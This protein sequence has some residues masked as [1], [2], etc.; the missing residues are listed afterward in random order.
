MLSSAF[1]VGLWTILFWI[2]I[3]LAIGGLLARLFGSTQTSTATALGVADFEGKTTTIRTETT[4]LADQLEAIEGVGPQI[5][6]LFHKNGV[7]RFAQIAAMSPADIEKI[8]ASGGS[9]FA[10]AQPFTWPFQAKLL[11]NGWIAEYLEVGQKLKAGRLPLTGLAGVGEATAERLSSVD[12]GSV[13]SLAAADPAALAAKLAASG[14]AISE[15]RLAGFIAEAQKLLAGDMAGLIAFF[16]LPAGVLSTRAT[17][18]YKQTQ[19]VSGPIVSAKSLVGGL[20]AATATATGGAPWWPVW[21]GL[22][23]AAI[24]ALLCLLRIWCPV[25]PGT[26]IDVRKT[27]IVNPAVEAEPEPAAPTGSGLISRLLDGKPLLIVYFETAKSDVANELTAE[28][29][30]LKAYL[31]THADSRLS[32]SGYVDPRGDAAFNEKLARDR[33]TKVRDALVA[34]G[35]GADRIDLDKPAD[36]V[37]DG[38]TLSAERKV[39]VKIKEGGVVAEGGDV[40]R[41]AAQ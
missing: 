31:D 19:D 11:E 25:Q 4:H 22:G 27:V 37:G 20:P 33:A 15:S 41:T 38:A 17:A 28:S 5:A 34:A 2:L 10:I 12:T 39:E 1:S 23:G 6:E 9:A 32:V 36:I 3:G 21:L 29:A 30:K 13:Q 16:G 7:H 35:I 40:T 8:L 26:T 24:L 14:D 18:S